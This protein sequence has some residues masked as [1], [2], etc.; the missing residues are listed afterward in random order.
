MF[1]LFDYFEEFDDHDILFDEYL[2]MAEQSSDEKNDY[3]WI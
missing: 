1:I 2:L 3:V